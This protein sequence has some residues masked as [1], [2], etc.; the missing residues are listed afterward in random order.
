MKSILKKFHYGE[1][2]FTLIEL[3][4]VVAILGI[5]AAVV[6]PNVMNMIGTGTVEAANTEWHDVEI[7]VLAAMV[8]N[9]VFELSPNGTV[10]DG[11]AA[12]VVSSVASGAVDISSDVEAKLNG[13]V[14]C[15]YNLDIDG[16]VLSVGTND[17][18][19][20]DL[21]FTQFTGWSE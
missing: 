15:E 6:I 17:G 12:S 19:W 7:A 8:Q 11:H 16:H 1:K 21:T 4:V 9:D 3:L 2:G 5:L 18:K 10:G 14:E 20:A 13:S